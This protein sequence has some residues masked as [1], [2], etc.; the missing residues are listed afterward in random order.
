[1]I[2]PVSVWTEREITKLGEDKKLYFEG[3][4]N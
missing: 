3:D 1:M 2:I 4:L